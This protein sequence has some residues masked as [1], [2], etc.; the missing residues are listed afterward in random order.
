[1][2]S[3]ETAPSRRPEDQ[4]GTPVG[5]RIV[6]A[7]LGLGAVGVAVG[8]RVTN[9]LSGV[10]AKDPT[11]LAQLLPTGGGFR[12]YSIAGP[13]KKVTPAE[14]TLSV[15]GLV[16]RPVHLTYDQL[17]AMPQT[18]L[19]HDFQCVTGWRVP[20]VHW[21]G[22]LLRD[23]LALASP[24]AEAVALRFTSFDHADTESLTLEQAHRDDVIVALQMLGAPVT[25]EHGGPVRLYVAP[26]YG[27]KSIKWLS[28]I[29]LTSSVIPGFWEDNGY[30]IDA[31]YSD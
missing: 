3:P 13:V 9:A 16:E 1:M 12:Y 5:R 30:P 22:V 24:T 6:L 27:Y 7:M 25:H 14:Y 26:M 20:D 4:R 28:G 10:E 15:T 17:A 21:S 31:Y 18:H 29:E 19:V 2:S 23:V 8:S 11:G